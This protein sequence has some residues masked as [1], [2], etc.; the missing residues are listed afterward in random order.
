MNLQK[1]ILDKLLDILEIKITF[2][3]VK[4]FLLE[5]LL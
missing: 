4:Y 1:Q 5:L 3:L 2:V